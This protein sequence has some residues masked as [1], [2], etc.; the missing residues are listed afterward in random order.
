MALGGPGLILQ[1]VGNEFLKSNQGL[2]GFLMS[3]G[4]ALFVAGLGYYAAAK[5]RSRWWGLC[6]F[7]SIVGFFVL[8]SLEDRS[9]TRDS[10]SHNK[11]DGIES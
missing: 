3:S 7:L 2:A 10:S 1:L 8:A 11:S 5:G 6:G 4:A 9:G